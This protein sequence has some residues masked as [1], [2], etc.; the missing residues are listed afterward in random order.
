M[1]TG[2]EPG[3]FD[4]DAAHTRD[5]QSDAT[6]RFIPYWVPRR[7]HHL[8]HAADR[9]P[10]PRQVQLVLGAQEDA[11]A[12]RHGAVRLTP[13]AAR[14][15][16]MITAAARS[17]WAA[18]SSVSSPPTWRST[19]SPRG[20]TPSRRTAT[21]TPPSSPTPAWWSRTPTRVRLNAAST[22]MAASLSGRPRPRSH[23][24]HHRRRLLPGPGRR[25][26]R[27]ARPAHGGPDLVARARGPAVVGHRRCDP[28]DLDHRPRRRPGPAARRSAHV[29]DRHRAGASGTRP[30]ATASSTSP[31]GRGPH[32]SRGRRPPRRA[33]PA[34]RRLQP[35]RRHRRGHG[36]RHLR[37]GGRAQRA[38]PSWTPRAVG[39]P[40]TSTPRPSAT[41]RS[42]T[43]SGRPAGR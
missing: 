11:P 14:D 27:R 35:L 39:S 16:L 4:R 5:P 26:R 18:A 21:G 13:S 19:T 3:A 32:P 29:V 10:R 34:R 33:R 36:A 12:L 23:G 41:A 9:L 30:C 43:R 37:G 25:R 22:G 20:W 1:G 2:W 15:V 42:P 28:A 7:V 31:T 6:G 8:R 40:P 24:V 17:S 38:P